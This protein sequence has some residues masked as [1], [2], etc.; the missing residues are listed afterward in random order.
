MSGAEFVAILSRRR[1]SH[2]AGRAVARVVFTAPS[3]P[4]IIH[5]LNQQQT[6]TFI[7]LFIHSF[8]KVVYFVEIVS[9]S[10]VF[11]ICPIVDCWFI[12]GPRRDGLFVLSIE[13]KSKRVMS[14][15][16]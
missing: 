3:D 11:K 9:T 6:T 10:T 14:D 7:Y 12:A 8:D 15:G 16:C 5:V 13:E 2:H 4:V 1:A